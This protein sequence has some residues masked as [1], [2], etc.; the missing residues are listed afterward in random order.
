MPESPQPRGKGKPYEGAGGASNPIDPPL[1]PLGAPAAARRRLVYNTEVVIVSVAAIIGVSNGFLLL[2]NVLLPFHGTVP[3][4]PEPRAPLDERKQARLTPQRNKKNTY[5]YQAARSRI[6][7]AYADSTAR[8]SSPKRSYLHVSYTGVASSRANLPLTVRDP[9]LRTRC[10]FFKVVP[11]RC[12][13]QR[14]R[15]P[16]DTGGFSRRI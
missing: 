3:G 5:Q 8:T 10:D 4:Q 12:L 13:Q 11:Y 14:I 15:S 2:S 9:Y 1:V 6:R 16:R 7:G